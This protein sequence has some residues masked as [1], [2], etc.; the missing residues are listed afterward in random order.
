MRKSV[1][2]G[3]L[4]VLALVTSPL[5]AAMATNGIAGMHGANQICDSTHMGGHWMSGHWNGMHETMHSVMHDAGPGSMGANW[6]SAHSG[7]VPCPQHDFSGQAQLPQQ[8]V[9]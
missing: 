7:E 4:A 3:A 6:D 9:E 2:I 8:H 1:L 5:W